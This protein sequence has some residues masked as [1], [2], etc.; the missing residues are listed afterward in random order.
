[1]ALYKFYILLL[2]I[3]LQ[4]TI[5]YSAIGEEDAVKYYYVDPDRGTVTIKQLLYPGTR[6]EYVVSTKYTC[7]SIIRMLNNLVC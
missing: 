3:I 6:T 7:M 4:D 2:L 5:K 1:M